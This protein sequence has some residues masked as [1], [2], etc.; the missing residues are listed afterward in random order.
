MIGYSIIG[1]V[2][3][4]TNQQKESHKKSQKKYNLSHR[5]Q[6][7]DYAK[8]YRETHREQMNEYQRKWAKENRTKKRKIENKYWSLEENRERRRKL[9]KIYR[10]KNKEKINARQR[11]QFQERRMLCLIHYSGNP[12]KCACCGETII[13]FL[14][15]DHINNDGYKHRQKIMRKKGKCP[16]GTWLW[17]WLIKNNFPEGFQVLCWNCNCGRDKT[18]DKVCPHKRLGVVLT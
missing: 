9:H 14:T 10:E 16:S 15:I 7:R 11:E 12:P 18:N 1:D 13:E 8:N 3:D 6:L 4:K 2:M 17:Y 5:Q